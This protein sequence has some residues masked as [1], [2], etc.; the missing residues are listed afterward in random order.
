MVIRRECPIHDGSEQM[1]CLKTKTTMQS[2]IGDLY[3]K[4]II[5]M[6]DTHL[7]SRARKK[8][9]FP[10]FLRGLP[11]RNCPQNPASSAGCLF[12][13]RKTRSEVPE[14]GD[15]GQKIAW[16]RVGWTRQKK[17]GCAKKR[18]GQE[19]VTCTP[20]EKEPSG[21]RQSLTQ[22]LPKAEIAPKKSATFSD[23]EQYERWKQAM[24]KELMAFLKTTWKKTNSR[25]AAH[26]LSLLCARSP[27]NH[28]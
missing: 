15:L 14:R 21:V 17:E 22:V 5:V 26:N 23:G 2:P 13:T 8:K 12:S 9:G 27:F 24:N 18:W 25:H 3:M 1:T 16:G 19:I 7:F 11:V 6:L 20:L 4:R 28:F 10:F